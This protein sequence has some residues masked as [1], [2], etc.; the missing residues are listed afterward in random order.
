[1][2]IF[3]LRQCLAVI[4]VL[5]STGAAA[6]CN[7]PVRVDIPN[8]SAADRDAMVAGQQA[9]KAYISEMEAYLE[10]I[11]NEEKNIRAGMDNLDPETEQQREDVLNKKYNAAVEEMD[12]VA[13]SFNEEL[14]VYREKSQ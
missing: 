1:M 7:Y 2:Q 4:A 11:L 14:R 8:G 9:V 3:S 5:I 6:E 10:C 13:A 12:R